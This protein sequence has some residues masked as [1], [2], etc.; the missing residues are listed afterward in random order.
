ML[1][2]YSHKDPKRKV[3]KHICEV[4]EY[5]QLFGVN[6]LVKLHEII[7]YAHD[8]GKY[9]IYF[10]DRLFERKNWGGKADH[11][12]VSAILGAYVCRKVIGEDDSIFPLFVFSVILSHHGDIKDFKSDQYLPKRTNQIRTTENVAIKLKDV[13]KQLD[14]MRENIEIIVQ[15][16][17]TIGWGKLV[18]AFLNEDNVLEETLLFLKNK[19]IDIEDSPDANNYL[20]HQF[21]YSCL[22]SAD[23]MSAAGIV[24]VKSKQLSY[25]QLLK[26]K[27]NLVAEQEQRSLDAVRNQIFEQVQQAVEELFDK[28]DFFSITAP[29]GTG[30]TFTGFFAAKKLQQLLGN[31]YKIIYTLPFTAIIDQNYDIIKALHAA[32]QDFGLNESLYLLKHHHLTDMKYR[33]EAEDYKQEQVELLIEN[34]D[35]GIVVTTFVQLLHTLIGQRNRMLKKYHVLAHSIIILDEVQAI[36]VKYYELINYLFK[37]ITAAYHCKIILMTATKPLLFDGTIE[38]LNQHEYYFSQLN[39]T[40]LYSNLKKVTVNEFCTQFQTT[41]KEDKSYLIVANTIKQSLMIYHHLESYIDKDNI[42]YLSANLLP[43]HRLQT[44]KEIR[45]KLDIKQK[46]VVVS[47]QVVEAGVDLDFDVVIRD[48]APIDSIIQCAGRC[49]RHNRPIAGEVYVICMSNQPISYAVQV[50]SASMIEVAIQTLEQAGSC[51]PENQYGKLIEQ[52]YHKLKIAV[53][54]ETSFGLIKAITQ[55]DFSFEQGVGTFSLIENNKDGYI[56]LFVEWDDIASDLLRLMEEVLIISD[57]IEQHKKIKVLN[58]KIKPYTVSIPQRCVGWYEAKQ[59]G[60]QTIYILE[61][62]NIG[63]F[64]SS[65]TGFKRDYEDTNFDQQFF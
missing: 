40:I 18:R 1:V 34:W 10:Q 50:Y 38:L 30:K 26:Q 5:S 45:A 8:F 31:Q 19:A 49:N 4:A 21:L 52:Y 17:Q 2:F 9:T 25:D 47:T 53:S 41:R 57:K 16:Y 48:M 62:N 23:K 12:F 7:A 44:L 39:R 15:D 32:D 22:I 59:L 33:N 58:K 20:H 42:Y 24:P 28:G 56:S 37:N 13:Y 54:Q 51:I 65:L 64:Y 14:N 63:K 43:V 3:I 46:I 36:P 60:R 6:S 61:Q 27:D 11:G 29:T 35:S 55:L